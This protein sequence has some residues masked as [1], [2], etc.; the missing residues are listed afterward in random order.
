M[1]IKTKIELSWED[2]A[3]CICNEMVEEGWE[4][5]EKSMRYEVAEKTYEGIKIMI[6]AVPKR[7]E[8]IYK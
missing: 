2:I 7:N 1:K 6:D 3:R 8:K 5:D 4:V